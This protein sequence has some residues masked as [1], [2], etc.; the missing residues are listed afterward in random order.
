MQHNSATLQTLG[1]F[2]LVCLTLRWVIFVSKSQLLNAC[3][4]PEAYLTSASGK[5]RY[6][7]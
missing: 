6:L 5:S 2:L 4:A 1:E 3:L 7:P